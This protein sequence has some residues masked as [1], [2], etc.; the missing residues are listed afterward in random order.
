MR[1][2]YLHYLW[3]FQK[4]EH[5]RLQTSDGLPV[6]VVSPGTHN[7]FSG[8][9]FFNA[10]LL[11]GGQQWAGNLEI[12]L[13]SSDWYLH[14][15][16]TDPA[17]DNVILHVVWEHDVEVFRKDNSSLPVV[18]IKHLVQNGALDAYNELCS[19]S[20]NRWINCEDDLPQIEEF[21]LENWLERLYLERLEQKTALINTL[22]EKSAGDWEAV[23]FQLLAR[24][25]GLNVN[26]EAF[27]GIAR[28][29]P[30]GVIRKTRGNLLQL[31]SLLLGQGGFLKGDHEEPYYR[32]LQEEYAYLKRKFALSGEGILPSKYF[33]LRPDNFPEIRLVQLAAVYHK[34]ENLFSSLEKISEAQDIYQLFQIQL[35]EFW[36]SH[37]TF[38]SGHRPRKK[39]FSRKFLDLLIIN[40]VVPVKFSWLKSKGKAIDGLFEIMESI[41]PEENQIIKKFRTLRPENLNNALQSQGFLQLKKEY[42]DKN[43]CLQCAVGLKIL[44]KE[45]Q[46]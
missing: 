35:N 41:A 34:N 13:R 23:L 9:D 46:I 27:M 44:Q 21:L 37:Y 42:C 29:I 43:A 14:G 16:E 31:E 32:K 18:E 8:P 7:L 33:R 38:S 6:K 10:R 36:S 26:G 19:G 2:D 11:I 4:I 40:T 25:F 15:H 5:W 45:P 17:Y 3:K 12:H 22:L 1:E 30:F 28:S 39:N 24:N 20:S